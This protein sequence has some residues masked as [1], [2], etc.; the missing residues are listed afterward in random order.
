MFDLINIFDVFLP[1]LLLYPNPSSPLNPEA[2]SLMMKDI[3]KYNDKVM[4]NVKKYAIGAG[5]V[6]EGKK[7][8]EETYRKS[9]DKM[10]IEVESLDEELSDLSSM[11][12]VSELSATSE[13]ELLES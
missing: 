12:D 9:E 10:D 6:L 13:I 8:M 5:K 11:S 1:Q 3:N 7:A 4:E 2:A